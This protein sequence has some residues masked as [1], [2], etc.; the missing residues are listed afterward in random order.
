MKFN[1]IQFIQFTILTQLSFLFF[2][3]L[4]GW[5]FLCLTHR[6]RQF[7]LSLFG[8]SF[9]SPSLKSRWRGIPNSLVM[10]TSPIVQDICARQNLSTVNL[11]WTSS[12]SIRA[13]WYEAKD[14]MSNQKEIERALRKVLKQADQ[15]WDCRMSRGLERGH[16]VG[17][18]AK[19]FKHDEKWYA[20]ICQDV[21]F[22]QHFWILDTS[23]FL[24]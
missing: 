22:S 14:A 10:F 4:G 19:A 9:R 13:V 16:L 2:R 1:S 24:P 20:L 15:G 12:L 11:W 23:V 17:G 7:G 5:H 8:A 21:L 6:R 3:S 18:S